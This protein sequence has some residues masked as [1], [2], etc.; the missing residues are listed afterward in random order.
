MSLFCFHFTANNEAETYVGKIVLFHDVLFETAR[1][2][3]EIIFFIA[4][5]ET[6]GLH[7]LGN[8]LQLAT[9][10]TEGVDDQTLKNSQQNDN[11]EEEERNVEHNSSVFVLFA[12]GRLDY[13]E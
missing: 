11:D 2:F 12:F 4:T 10:L 13:L 1:H 9:K 6:V 7:F 3:I 8:R 5:N